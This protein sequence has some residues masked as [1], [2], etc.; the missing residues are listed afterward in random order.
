MI[1]I[2]EK[3]REKGLLNKLNPSGMSHNTDEI[4]HIIVKVLA[5]NIRN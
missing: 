3:V 4:T 1:L 5:G 2:Q